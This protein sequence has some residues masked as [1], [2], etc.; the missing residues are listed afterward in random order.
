[1]LK[2]NEINTIM[3]MQRTWMQ[4]QLIPTQNAYVVNFNIT[5]LMHFLQ[6]ISFTPFSETWWL[7]FQLLE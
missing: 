3:K 1:M 5:F 7:L 4:K 6:Q 2:L